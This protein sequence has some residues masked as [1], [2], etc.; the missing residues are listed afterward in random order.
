MEKELP[1]AQESTRES[2][3][4][5]ASCSSSKSNP[6]FKSRIWKR[7]EKKLHIKTTHKQRSH[8][9]FHD[10]S[11]KSND[12]SL[13]R[14]SLNSHP[15][16]LYSDVVAYGNEAPTRAIHVVPTRKKVSKKKNKPKHVSSKRNTFEG[17]P[18]LA[19]TSFSED[20][21]E[22]V[23]SAKNEVLKDCDTQKTSD[24]R[25]KLDLQ[26]LFN[27]RIDDFNFT[28]IDDDPNSDSFPRFQKIF[29]DEDYLELENKILQNVE[30]EA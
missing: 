19:N 13:D 3:D 21:N 29:D 6:K 27:I 12:S 14:M 5:H 8:I 25:N 30:T 16:R 7:T 17:F 22:S 4:P 2:T 18:P 20:D 1:S 24:E 28:E 10:T 26:R 11:S 23:D 9:H 15:A